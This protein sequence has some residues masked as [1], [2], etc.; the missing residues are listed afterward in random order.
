M[1]TSQS[2]LQM[3]DILFYPEELFLHFLFV[4]LQFYT[5]Y[6]YVY[7]LYVIFFCTN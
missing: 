6:L 1:S 4:L 5:F 3:S 2:L 7:K